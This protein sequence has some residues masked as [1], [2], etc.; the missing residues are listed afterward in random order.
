MVVPVMSVGPSCQPPL[1]MRLA[2]ASSQ[3]RYGRAD[4]AG[5][6]AH[7]QLGR[8]DSAA[9]P[10][11]SAAAAARAPTSAAGT[12]VSGALTSRRAIG[13]AT[14]PRTRSGPPPQWRRRPARRRR[15]TSSSRDR[16]TRT[17]EPL[18]GVVAELQGR[19][20][21]VERAASRGPAP[22]IASGERPDVF[23]AAAVERAGQ[24]HRG[25]LRV[26][27][28]GPGQQVGRHARRA[29]GRDADADQDQPV[30]R[31]AALARPGSRSPRPWPARRRSAPSDDG[32]AGCVEDHDHERPRPADAPA[33]MPMMS[34]R[35][36]RVAGQRLEDR[37][38]EPERGADQHGRRARGAA[39]ARGR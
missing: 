29:R 2:R 20:D 31:D 32:V 39:A 21:R 37:A 34:G 18:G 16:S 12:S 7:R 13:A 8:A 30:R 23:P 24:P 35:G 33:V 6:D 25:A 22:A 15:A 17:P 19:S 1:P 38:G 14:K 5:D 10:T 11:R 26:V 4:D 27:D 9:G 28:L 3:I 36:E